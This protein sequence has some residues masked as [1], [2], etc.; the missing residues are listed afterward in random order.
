LLPLQAGVAEAAAEEEEMSEEDA[1]M[2]EMRIDFCRQGISVRARRISPHTCAN[3]CR[4]S[5]S[6]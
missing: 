4:M 6:A 5:L 3:A 2:P 1:K